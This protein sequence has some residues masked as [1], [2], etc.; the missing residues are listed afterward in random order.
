[1]IPEFGAPIW[2]L[3]SLGSILF[4]VRLLYHT[5]IFSICRNWVSFLQDKFHIYN[6]YKIPQ[7]NE[8]SQEN[9][10]FR[11]I[12]TYIRSLPSVEESDYAALYSGDNPGNVLVSP[13][14]EQ[15]VVDAFLH[16]RVRWTYQKCD[17]NQGSEIIL[18]IKS[19]DRKTI[20]APYIQHIYKTVDDIEQ[21]KKELRIHVNCSGQWRS[22]P[23][24]H[25]ASFDSIVLDNDVK[26]KVKNDLELF[27]K[28]RRY[29]S[30]IGR[31][32]KRSYLLYGGSGT[33]KS[34][35]AAAMTKY[36]SY[37]LYDIDI[38]RISNGSDL[39]TLLLQTTR[40]SVILVEN[41]DVYLSGNSSRVSLIEV[42][43]FMDGVASSCGEERI[44]IFTMNSKTQIDPSVLRP[45]RVDVHIYFP[46]CDFN[47]FKALALSHLGV[48]EHKLFGEVEELIQGGL[49]LISHAEISEI[50]ISNRTS[51]SRAIKSV[52][53]TLRYD[54]EGVELGVNNIS[55][56]GRIS[57][58]SDESGSGYKREGNIAMREIQ[59]FYGMMKLRNSRRQESIDLSSN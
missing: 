27:M 13:G 1:M 34:S 24:V 32:W 16:A 52:I 19:R 31:V 58:D 15:A 36:L 9:L 44:M 21:R 46:F 26:N 28:S 43:N 50:M 7:F 11:K 40:K 51:S 5:S 6:L 59:K 18:K 14:S 20:L 12:S 42:I 41:L 4:I 45:G 23:F 53:K 8:Y 30:K 17:S 2:L 39:K 22:F 48:K 25:P 3:I 10:L 33:G 35:F 54:K 55:G 56:G 57:G 29:Y 49:R 37:D 38:S 47:G